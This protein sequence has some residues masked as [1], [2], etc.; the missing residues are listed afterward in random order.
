MKHCFA[1]AGPV[2]VT[3]SISVNGGALLSTRTITFG[4]VLSLPLQSFSSFLACLPVD[5]F[6]LEETSCSSVL[7]DDP[8]HALVTFT[9]G[10]GF[11][12]DFFFGIAPFALLIFFVIILIVIISLILLIT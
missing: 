7:S 1:W 10:G 12:G 2:P 6:G 5:S 8:F 11:L 3:V 9:F 4:G